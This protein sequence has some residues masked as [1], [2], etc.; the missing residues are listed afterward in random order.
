MTILPLRLTPFERYFVVDERPEYPMTF[1]IV[2]E[3]QGVA[4]ETLVEAAF[5]QTLERHPLQRSMLSGR[6]KWMRWVPADRL[7]QVEW[8][9]QS[10]TSS[11]QA[12]VQIDLRTDSPVRLQVCTDES[13]TQFRFQFHHAATDGIGGMRF[14]GDFLAFYGLG[15]HRLPR[16]QSLAEEKLADRGRFQFKIPH[17][18]SRWVA[19]KS[20]LW[21]TSRTVFRRA[22][23]LRPPVGADLGEPR[24]R[25][26]IVTRTVDRR[27]FGRYCDVAANKNVTPN[28]LMVRDAFVTIRDWVS[29]D[30]KNTAR[31]WMRVLMPTSL[32]SRHSIDSPAANILG[33][34]I[35]MRAEKDNV[36]S[37]EF[38]TA[39]GKETEFVRDWGLGIFFVDG[40]KGIDRVPGG[41]WLACRLLRRYATLALS[42]L[43]NPVRRFRAKFEA[44]ELGQILSG[45]LRVDRIYG[46]PPV[47]PGTSVSIALFQYAGELTVALCY[48]AKSWT[49][50]IAAQF[51]DNY[52]KQIRATADT[53]GR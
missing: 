11:V 27:T 28:D 17:P 33:Y 25:S 29:S 50:P 36:D 37:D 2:V 39:L 38:L 42:N 14:V 45:N 18:V 13:T 49:E 22:S 21:E 10:P 32:R 4:D 16:H 31:D 7:P 8:S 3:C 1:P 23:L 41:L 9:G 48:D 43:G 46:C 47:R 12:N 20:M 51:L 5:A 52:V 34:A 35:L 40:V 53:D 26:D 15:N 44:T 19:T 30:A 6:G 24:T